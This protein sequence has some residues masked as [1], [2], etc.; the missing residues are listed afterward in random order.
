[1][2]SALTSPH[3]LHFRNLGGKGVQHRQVTPGTGT[4]TTSVK[5]TRVSS[6]A[7][8]IIQNYDFAVRAGSEIIYEGDTYFGFFT[9][10]TLAQQVGIREARSYIPSEAEMQGAEQATRRL[11]RL[12]SPPFPDKQLRMVDNIDLYLPAGGPSKLGFIQGSKTIDPDEWF[13]KA[14]FHQD[15]VWP[16]SLGLEAFVQLLQVFALERW[17][18]KP[19]QVFSTVALGKPHRWLYRGQVVPANREVTVQAIITHV[20]DDRRLLRADG[21]LMVDGLAIYQM[22]DFTLALETG[23]R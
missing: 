23:A 11:T 10:E 8:M 21:Y 18:K 7:G 15:P 20:G 13:F 22:N 1:M 19:D 2:G 4:L 5:V 14:H 16:G 12:G 3:D 17:G 9:P 6:S